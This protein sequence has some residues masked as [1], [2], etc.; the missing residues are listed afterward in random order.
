MYGAW[1]TISPVRRLLKPGDAAGVA[2]HLALA[3]WVFAPAVFS[4]RLPYLRDVSTYFHPNLVHLERSLRAG[5]VPLWHPGAD[6][7]SPFLLLYPV[8]LALVA[9]GGA[10]LALLAGPLLHTL[11]AALGM[12]ALA[13]RLGAAPVSAWTSGVVFALSGFMLSAVNLVP[14]HQAAAWAPLVLLAALSCADRAR[15]RDAAWLAAAL[16]LQVS[17]LAGEIVA[18]TLVAGAVLV[19]GRVGRRGL[20]A[21][22]AAGALA[23]LL[24]AP[25]LCGIAALLR[26]THRGAGFTA[27]EALYG[28]AAPIEL[29]GLV[30]PGFFGDMHTFT[31]VGFWGQSVFPGGFPYL[32]SLYAGLAALVLAAAAGRDRLWWLAAAGVLLALG[33]HGPLGAAVGALGVFRAP[34]KFLFV[35]SL[36]LALLAARGLDR[37]LRAPRPWA[38]AS[39]GALVLALAAA[40]AVLP[41]RVAG[42]LTSEPAAAL[43]IGTSWP[44]AL[45]TAGLAALAAGVVLA[46]GGRLAAAAAA[47]VAIDLVAANGDVNRF[48]PPDFYAL[49]PEVRQLLTPAFADRGSRVFGYG[50]G[51]TPGLRFAPAVLRENA[52]VRLYYLDR[53]VLWGRTPVLD[54][55][56]GALDEDR[57]AWAP[58]GASL[59]AAESVPAALPAV[60]AR[61]REANV[62]WLLSFA[63]LPAELATERGAAELPEVLAPLRLYE[64]AGA[65]PRAFHAVDP[66]AMAAT[67]DARVE[68][69]PRGPHA[70]RLRARTPPGY[71]VWLSGWNPGWRAWDA[72]GTEVPLRRAGLRSIALAT[73][74]GEQVFE[75]R[76]APRWW[77]WSLA[78][79]ALGALLIAVA[80]IPWT[81]PASGAEATPAGPAPAAPR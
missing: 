35:A 50:I 68:V 49:R 55:L 33:A 42:M 28:S 63:P 66:V 58:A 46:R 14:L 65:L 81:R 38:L 3:L 36:A 53:Q 23:A 80:L 78:A 67:P 48:A 29:A 24:A 43:V 37:A 31:N 41:A 26:G 54:G 56:E 13:R 20:A 40:A 73:A 75:L 71:V 32:L 52:D 9:L 51:N 77:P 27:A 69:E 10:R 4:G 8:D 62:R 72:A 64:L 44:P 74:G 30:L 12:T 60:H 6:G 21:M 47:L 17:T 45:L 19:A 1:Y 15:P 59:S 34:V 70:V 39:P 57:T 61:M 11:L 79:A 16:A 22:A 18:Q 2:A 5:V 25:V 76:F 7:G